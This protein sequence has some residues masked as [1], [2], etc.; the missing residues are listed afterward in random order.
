M[1]APRPAAQ[2]ARE[3]PR[4]VVHATF[5]IEREYLASLARTYSAWTSE[6]AKRRWFACHQEYALDFREGGTEFTRGG[7]PG[8]PVWTCNTRFHDIVHE[9]RIVYS[10][11]LLRDD[12]RVSV[13]LVTVTFAMIGN[14]TR[15]TF[16][17]QSAFLDG[18]DTP[19]NREHGTREGLD[20]LT[21]ELETT[22][23]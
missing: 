16:T 1:I 13:S 11:E 12:T 2:P 9:E 6:E 17:E 5:T 7:E 4:D 21:I 10:Y 14:G 8:G 15:L 22:N 23:A 20:R 18:H 3:H 19:A